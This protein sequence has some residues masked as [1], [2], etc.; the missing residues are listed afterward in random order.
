MKL[1]SLNELSD[2]ISLYR[3]EL[4][5]E[6]INETIEWIYGIS[7]SASEDGAQILFAEA[8]GCLICAYVADGVPE[9]FLYPAPILK[10]FCEKTALSLIADY[11]RVNEIREVIYDVP[12][13]KLP[14]V[15]CGVLHAKVDAVSEESYS[16]RIETECMLAKDYPELMYDDIYLS[17][18]TVNFGNEYKRLIMDETVNKYTGYDVRRENPDV[19]A[20][21]L[22]Y[23]AREEFYGGKSVTLFATISDENGE[24]Q[25]IGE[26]VLYH[27]D[28][29]GGAEV[30]VRLLP[31]FFG[32]GYGKK[33]A[34]AMIELA[35]EMNLF[36]LYAIVEREN[37][38][39]VNLFSSL[40]QQSYENETEIG[41]VLYL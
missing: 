6:D 33:L 41:F 35:E 38:V 3:E 2:T 26:A 23:E 34:K 18:P 27:F 36:R 10:E 22:V 20:E 11:C 7:E 1:K 15:L 25:F 5:A 40:M 13:E 24:N 37:T 28:G 14:A 17:E 16:V 32:K 12:S 21:F 29:R 31:E 30:A 8:A 9:F 4:L 39:S 19:D